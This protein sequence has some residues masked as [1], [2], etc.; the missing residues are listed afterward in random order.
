MRW[1]PFGKSLKKYLFN[2]ANGA[3]KY[4]FWLGVFRKWGYRLDFALTVRTPCIKL[5]AKTGAGLKN[6]VTLVNDDPFV[7]V[8]FDVNESE[9]ERP[10]CTI[11]N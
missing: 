7:C 11:L 3:S 1:K 4:A 10:V 9:I 8:W 6:L 2:T 5:C